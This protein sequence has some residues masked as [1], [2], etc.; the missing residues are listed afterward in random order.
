MDRK[1][2]VY[3]KKEGA[4]LPNAIRDYSLPLFT[5]TARI[6]V[7]ETA[8]NELESSIPELMRSIIL[9][10]FALPAVLVN[11]KGDILYISGRT[12]KY[13]D[14]AS[15]KA[16][17]NILAMAR[18]DLRFEIGSAIH[19]AA[20]QN[21]SVTAKDISVRVNGGEQHL[22]V[23]VKPLKPGK[24]SE[25]LMVVFEDIK[26]PEEAVKGGKD[27]GGANVLIERELH[28]T[29]ER[30]NA[31]IEEMQVSQEEYRA[32]NEELETTNEEL[33][34]TN[35]ELIS[36]KEEMQSLNEE[37]MSVNADLQEKVAALHEAENDMKNLL[38]STEIATL[39]LDTSLKV[40]RFTP[41]A[42]K[43]IKLIKGDVGRP[44]T[45]I[46][47]NLK[48]DRLGEDAAEVLE[49]L[50]TKEMEV[51][52]KDGHWYLMRI[53]PYRTLENVIQ[54]V[55]ITFTGITALKRLEMAVR[56]ERQYAESILETIREPLVV[57]DGRLRVV[58]A[59]RSFYR[60]F[61]VSPDETQNR[62]IFS[63]GNRQWDIPELRELLEKIIPEKR[64]FED[65]R[66]E[67]TFPKIGRKAMILNARKIEQKAGGRELILLA[68]EDVAQVSKS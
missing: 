7:A 60:T 17:L 2:R 45:D 3:E 29:K 65:F 49:K 63:L 28:R 30:L 16:N 15:G 34:S 6:N 4:L 48:Y 44:I 61:H 35:E 41:E 50:A 43:I 51:E 57:L 36:S 13:L 5:P 25:L 18:E 27:K 66:V 59:N 33:Q 21:T 40:R 31:T 12:G 22:N 64:A 23:I 8:K 55:V 32:A 37:L 62:L 38:N 46:V 9:E 19:K 68:I 67:H 39:F 20:T 10:N 24:E 14:P 56:E 53:L 26:P 58:S 11:R 1:W 52:S 54:G 42:A 47:S